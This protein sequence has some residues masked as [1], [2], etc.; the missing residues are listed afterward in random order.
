VILIQVRLPRVCWVSCGRVLGVR[1][2]V[3][4]ALLRNPLADPMCSGCRAV[5]HWASP[6]HP[7]GGRHHVVTFPCYRSVDLSEDCCRYGGLSHGGIY[8]RLPIHALLLA[9]VILNAIFSAMIM[10]VTSIMERI[11]P[12]GR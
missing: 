5:R 4:Q 2:V 8:D 6:R 10:F 7:S 12:S 9:G 11:A 3:L 1:R